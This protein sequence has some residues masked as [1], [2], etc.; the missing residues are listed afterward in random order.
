MADAAHSHR[1]RPS[2][3][4]AWAVADGI[5]DDWDP[6][7]AAEMAAR[8][9]ARA[10]TTGGSACGI[11]AARAELQYFY[12]GAPRLQTGDCVMVTAAPMADHTGAGLDI[13]WVGDCR[14]GA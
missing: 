5:G 2:G 3:H 1:H 7:Q 10:A 14:S 4:R 11:A 12:D 13:A 9:A 8:R 6:A